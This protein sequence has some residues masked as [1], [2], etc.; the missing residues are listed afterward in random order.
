MERCR[1]GKDGGAVHTTSR[2]TLAEDGAATTLRSNS[3]GGRY[4]RA[5]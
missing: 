4:H 5:I 1:A 3:A 2:L